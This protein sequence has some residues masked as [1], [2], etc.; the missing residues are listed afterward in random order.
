MEPSKF[1][2]NPTNEVNN[3]QGGV[4]YLVHGPLA[5]PAKQALIALSHR[6]VHFWVELL[7]LSPVDQHLLAQIVTTCRVAL[8]TGFC[9]LTSCQKLAGSCTLIMIPWCWAI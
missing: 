9:C 8:I 4:I 7:P 6:L 1:K 2:A 3:P 5:A